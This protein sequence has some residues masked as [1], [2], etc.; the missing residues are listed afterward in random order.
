MKKFVLI[1]LV[2]I[3]GALNANA[4]EVD[5]AT[6]EQTSIVDSLSNELAELQHKYNYLDVVNQIVCA[7]NETQIFCNEVLITVNSTKITIYHQGFDLDLYLSMVDNYDLS[8]KSFELLKM[9]VDNVKTLVTIRKLLSNFSETEIEIIDSNCKALD[10]ALSKVEKS[11]E[12]NKRVLDI[13]KS[14][15]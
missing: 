6:T 8:V 1:V 14:L 10:L 2:A 4:Q 15:R 9:K 5:S 7:I 11:L 13:Y 12:Y 3:L